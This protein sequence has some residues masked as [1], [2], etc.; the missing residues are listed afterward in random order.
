MGLTGPI[1]LTGTFDTTSPLTLINNLTITR[2]A[3]RPAGAV[4]VN[5]TAS[6]DV[7]GCIRTG[8]EVA[9]TIA[10]S[11]TTK[12]ARGTL[13]EFTWMPTLQGAAFLVFLSPGQAFVP[14]PIW[15][16]ST[17]NMIQ[18]AADTAEVGNYLYNYLIVAF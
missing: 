15:A 4:G 16:L 1:G 7:T 18:I 13:C 10:F 14:L 17:A 5:G 2:L 6:V 11:V 9:G 12:K 8:N 3:T